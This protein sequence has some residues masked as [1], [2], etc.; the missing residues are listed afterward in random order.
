MTSTDSCRR[1]LPW[2]ERLEKL[3]AS[4]CFWGFL[5][6]AGLAVRFR[7]YLFGHSY[8]YDES[9]LVLVIQERGFTELLGP[10]PYNLVIPPGFLWITR[11]LY[12]IAGKSELL[13]RLPAFVAG[14]A[15][16][17]LMIPL[18][19]R[20]VGSVH[21][22]WAFAFLVVSRHAL[23]H[24]CD[25]RPYTVD[26]LFT[27]LIL[28]ATALVITPPTL[29]KTRQW[30]I[31]AL[32]TAAAVGPWLSFPSVFVLGGASLALA[33][34]LP[35]QGARNA[36][37]MWAAFNGVVALSAALLWWFSGRH[38]YYTGMIEHWGH[39][40]WWGFPD[41]SSLF[42]I[43]KWLLWRPA[44][45]GNYGN[46]ELGVV[47]S[48]LA[49][50]GVI[51]LTRQSRALASLLVAPFALA[52]IAALLG[53]YPLAHRTGFFLLPCIWLLAA[54]GLA[55][56]AQWGLQRG[57]QL[58]LV[59]L[60]LISWDLAWVAIRIVRPDARLD[61]RGAY[62]IE[63]AQRQPGDLL[64]TETSVV[65]QVYY[66]KHTDH[67]LGDDFTEA[68]RLV[69]CRRLWLVAGDTRNDLWKRLEAAGGRMV[70]RHHVSGL[71]V[72]LFEPSMSPVTP[73]R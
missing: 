58:A 27:V 51:S 44:E 62:Q 8:W 36:W 54:A 20:V 52:V 46:R 61:Y 53:R 10:Q 17:L 66:G 45:I 33:I 13:L 23:L 68:E 57:W 34:S 14:I 71:E 70:K 42:A 7:Q 59:G 64:W 5:L 43:G 72:V 48:L 49:V 40:G 4:P 69:K 73:C 19:R 55:F 37:L 56:L 28:C 31:A 41:W 21:A 16:L 24:G 32:A 26:L 63:E 2:S 38:M 60:L 11:A 12:E 18:A 29:A 50:M 39:R 25:V 6:V 22:I 30:A 47:L 3:L 9:F 67:L 65:H 35:R 1:S 15:A